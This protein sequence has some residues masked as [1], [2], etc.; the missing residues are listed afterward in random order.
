MAG[1][2]N[3]ILTEA[4]T[5]RRAAGFWGRLGAGAPESVTSEPHVVS[6]LLSKKPGKGAARA[7]IWTLGVLAADQCALLVGAAGVRGGASGE[8]RNGV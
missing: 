6:T 5:E 2:P 8:R 1:S 3:H 4:E 7:V